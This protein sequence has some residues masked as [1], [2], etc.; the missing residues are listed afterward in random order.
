M[1]S[2]HHGR[3]EKN[4]SP[5][6]AELRRRREESGLSLT[7]LADLIPCGKSHLSKVERGKSGASPEFAKKCDDLLVAKGEL[8]ALMIEK[9][10]KKAGNSK[11]TSC[12]GIPPSPLHFVGRSE[13]LAHIAGFFT[14]ARN[15]VCVLSGL[16][17]TGKTALALQAAW[18]LAESFPDG[19]F[20]IDLEEES[21]GGQRTGLPA[22]LDSL[23]RLLGVPEE[24]M[25]SRPDALANLWRS[26]LKDKRLLLVLDN[27]AT[28]AD[29]TPLLSAE[30]GYKLLAT[31][32]KRLN[33]LDDAVQLPVGVL[34]PEEADALF[35]AVGGERAT[36]AAGR[37]VRAVV[38]HC[39]RL[40]LA[41][42]IAAARFRTG[43]MRTVEELEVALSLETDRLS[44]LDDGD[45]SVTAALN[46]SC[47]GLTEEQRRLF[48]L[49][50][51]Y[52][53]QGADLRGV[54]ALSGLTARRAG[55][56][57]ERLADAYLVA[58]EP[59]G[60][61]T[62]H[63]FV[64]Q[65][66]CLLLPEVPDG[67][68]QAA[69]GRLLEY[70][71]RHAVAADRQLTPQRYRPPVLLD[72]FPGTP[73]RFDGRDEALGWLESEW[74]CLAALC[75]T[76][77]EQG[78]HSLCWQLAFA[79]RE[80]FFL[81]K[82]WGPWVETHRLA[83]DSART[84]GA[85]PWLA[86]SLSNLGV[87]HA[88]RGDLTMAVECYRQALALYQEMGDENGVV[89]AVSNIAWAELYLGDYG[90]A[91]DGLRNAMDHYHRLGNKRNAA[92]TLRG[93]A[94][95]EAELQFFPAAVRHA[96]E[97]REEFLS[98]GLELDVVMSVN[99]AAW[100]HFQAG[101]HDAARAG[102]EEALT[103]AER[104]GSRYECARALTGLG[105]I[106]QAS[107]QQR[108]ATDLWARADS[109]YGGLAPVM[110]GE[111]RVRLA[112]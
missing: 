111:A 31:S 27:A 20:F 52:P 3:M 48:T 8:T 45:R 66:A 93:I 57:L 29:I 25:P 84:A 58:Y 79:L 62:M 16:P 30:P 7:G 68:Q 42:R 56:L 104:C 83:V 9:K 17:G 55:L 107:G 33:A 26:R 72:D 61:I 67:E 6:G 4:R 88:D 11:V 5:F 65:F 24:R 49:L 23:L 22:V 1:F 94:L 78:L 59:S 43:S 46:V 98:L 101:D 80:F 44:L 99:C 81:T 77:A 21:P 34:E 89:N 92:I 41:V 95:L 71:L 74:R 12:M 50:A 102:Y 100:A 110:L 87:A 82:R 54:I 63:D 53:V 76:A 112:S 73:V 75:R 85:R 13:E 35:R 15:T 106:H 18:N 14:E 40:P 51:L 103:L 39:G 96:H 32:R 90:K 105:N 37:T 70:G 38:E 28:A 10:P 86:I 36:G 97:A 2:G 64:R 19:C 60:R 108:E 109:L 91:L 47:R 69:V